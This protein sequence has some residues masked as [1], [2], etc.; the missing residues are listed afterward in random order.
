MTQPYTSVHFFLEFP[1]LG[2]V[3]AIIP[4]RIFTAVEGTVK[5][6]KGL[7]IPAGR[8]GKGDLTAWNITD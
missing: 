3:G 8:I 1:H 5:R 6:I 2:K 7:I 4:Y